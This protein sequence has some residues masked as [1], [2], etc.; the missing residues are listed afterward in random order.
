MHTSDEINDS[1]YRDDHTPRGTKTGRNFELGEGGS[2][3]KFQM[4]VNTIFYY[5]LRVLVQIHY[6]YYVLIGFIRVSHGKQ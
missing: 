3:K 2:L 6:A 5:S 4:F 1:V